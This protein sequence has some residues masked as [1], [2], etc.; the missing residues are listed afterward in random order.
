[1]KTIVVHNELISDPAGMH[2]LCP[3]GAIVE[4]GGDVQIT[5]GCRMCLLCVKKG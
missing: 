1:M 4:S 5:S 2:K 3:F